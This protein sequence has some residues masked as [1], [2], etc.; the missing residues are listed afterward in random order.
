MVLMEITTESPT[1]TEQCSMSI[2]YFF[3]YYDFKKLVLVS[4]IVIFLTFLFSILFNNS[5]PIK[6]IFYFILIF[7]I[8][9][10]FKML[11]DQEKAKK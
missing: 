2:K 8:S 1:T 3:K 4:I 6:N 7:S 11:A 9:L 10:F 5:F